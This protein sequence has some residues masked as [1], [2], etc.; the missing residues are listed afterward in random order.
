MDDQDIPVTRSLK[1]WS[2]GDAEGAGRAIAHLYPALHRI[3][4]QLLASERPDHT[5]QPTALINEL[6]RRL[7]D[8]ELPEW[9]NRTHFLAVAANTLRRILIDHARAQR[10]QRRGGKAVKVQSDLIDIGSACSYEDLLIID[11]TLD[12][13]EKADP[14]AARVAELRF[15]TGLEASEIAAELGI[16]EVTVNRDWRFARAW[17][18]DRLGLQQ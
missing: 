5:L 13:L 8:A 14:R 9:R 10:A 4:S 12:Q 3:A 2:R 15:F 17:L 18:A 11:E 16:S 6:Y 1:E 7:A